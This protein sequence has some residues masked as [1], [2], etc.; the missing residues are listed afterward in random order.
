LNNREKEDPLLKMKTDRY[1]IVSAFV[2]HIIASVVLYLIGFNIIFWLKGGITYL[3]LA[4]PVIILA[5]K[6]D[7]KAAPA[8]IGSSFVIGSIVGIIQ[9]F[10]V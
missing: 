3:I 5:A 9:R 10:I 6:D 8:M 2:F 1:S 4:I 7:K